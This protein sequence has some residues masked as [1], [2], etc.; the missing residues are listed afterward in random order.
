[1]FSLQKK[2]KSDGRCGK[3]C[4]SIKGVLKALFKRVC[5]SDLF[6]LIASKL[7]VF[8]MRFS[9][10]TTRWSIVDEHFVDV[11]H[12]ACRP[13]IAC[14]WHDRLM[15]APCIWKWEQPLHVLASPHRDGRLIAKIVESFSMPAIFGSTGHGISAAKEIIRLLQKGKYVAIIPDGPRGPRHKAA[16]GVVAIAK[17]AK[18]DIVMFSF[19]VKRYHRFNSWDRFIFSYPFN[20]GVIVY[21]KP[22]GYDE[23]ITMD[24]SAALELLEHRINEASE[25][26]CRIL[27]EID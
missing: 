9:F 5:R 12:Q 2:E 21:G 8:L 26:A 10:R 22:I 17:I 16:P 23:L 6:L 25:R 20:R 19:C 11:Y 7:M 15:Q 1:M 13:F 4:S 3:I 14:L 24:E 27:N 18:V